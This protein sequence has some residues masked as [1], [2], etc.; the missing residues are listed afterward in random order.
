MANLIPVSSIHGIRNTEANKRSAG[1]MGRFDPWRARRDAI[2]AAD[3]R[4]VR[5]D[6]CDNEE[7]AGIPSR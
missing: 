6:E 2:E 5:S 7:P 1:G 3:V 4:K